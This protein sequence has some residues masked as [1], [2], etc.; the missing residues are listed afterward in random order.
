M[1]NILETMALDQ[2]G[3][4]ALVFIGTTLGTI[5]TCAAVK[6]LC[7]AIGKS[8]LKGRRRLLAFREAEMDI[9]ID[10][11]IELEMQMKDRENENQNKNEKE[12]KTEDQNNV[13]ITIQEIKR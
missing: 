1:Q 7:H 9:E 4:L 8:A 5:I 11:E 10:R 6:M 2:G 12:D 3:F 13:V